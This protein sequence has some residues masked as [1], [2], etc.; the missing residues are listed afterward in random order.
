MRPELIIANKS[1]GHLWEVS[2]SV[3]TASFETNR[4]G[5]PGTFRF[6]VVK[7]GDLSFTEGDTVRFS[8]DG[9]LV[10]YG[11]VFSKSK[12]RWGVI[13]VT[14]YDRLRYLKANASYAFYGQTAP[15][16]IR[17]IA[18]DLQLPVGTLDPTGYA[19]PS[20]IQQDKCCLDIIGEAVQQT[21]LNTGKIYTFFDGGD[22]LSLRE[23]G[24]MVS[25]TVVGEGSLLLDY[26]YD[27]SID[28][29]T[30][31]SVKLVRPDERTG[32]M[33]AFVAQDS[34]AIA[35]WGLLRLYQQV[36]GAENDAQM[37]ARAAASLR[38]F[39]RRGR[40]LRVSALGVPGLRAGQ[41]VPVYLPGLGDRDLKEYVLLDRVTHTWEHGRHTMEFETVV[42]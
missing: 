13:Q 22:G 19:L 25:D 4:T 24:A 9:Q 14:C 8:V 16:I 28:R 33:D 23:A 7:A 5:S 40:S 3:T 42:N 20:L 31:N 2:N 39:N 6:S 10:F 35:Q 32:R 12:D 18:G 29:Q 27:T 15:D 41:M 30:Y 34:G 11:W 21:L 37:K 26:A 1:G 17:Q 38:Y 36:D